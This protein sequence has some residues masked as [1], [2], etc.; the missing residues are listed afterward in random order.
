MRSRSPSAKV[1]GDAAFLS[2]Y[3]DYLL[4]CILSLQ[5]PYD[6]AQPEIHDMEILRGQLHQLLTMSEHNI[7][8]IICTVLFVPF[9]PEFCTFHHFSLITS[10]FNKICKMTK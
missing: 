2:N 6:G 7:P 10:L 3:F 4:V 9:S 1:H 5:T 8:G